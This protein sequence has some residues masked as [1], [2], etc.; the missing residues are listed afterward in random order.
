MSEPI[1]EQL[2]HLH[3]ATQRLVRGV[4]AL[5]DAAYAEPSLLPGWSRSHVVA[6]LAL[7]AEGLTGVLEGVRH[8]EGVPMYASSEA[9]GRDI[10]AL[11]AAAPGVVRDRLLAATTTF[12]DAAHGVPDD[13]WSTRFERTPGGPS[14][15][16]AAAVGMRWREVE[17]HHV[18]LGASYDRG[19][20]TVPFRV[21][22]IERMG[23]R[24][25]DGT[26]LTVH[27]TDLERS[28]SFGDGGPTVS[29][30]AAD[31]AWW[32]TGRGDG[33]G[34]TSDGGVLPGI[35]AW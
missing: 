33:D 28:W 35:E 25:S 30:S 15:S 12:A 14:F 10:E 7:N 26:A 9:R 22:V 16:A 8:G 29:G 31:L 23:A 6:H 34:L 24:L 18:D 17:I 5:P 21:H 32:L 2:E 4:D 13:A 11:A 19:Q 27:A 3:E 20:W 1:D